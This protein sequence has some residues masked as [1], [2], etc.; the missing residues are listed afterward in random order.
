M[1]IDADTVMPERRVILHPSLAKRFGYGFYDDLGSVVGSRLEAM[2]LLRYD[3]SVSL[4]VFE[5]LCR[6]VQ[7]LLHMWDVKRGHTTRAG[8]IVFPF[9]AAGG[10]RS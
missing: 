7:W 5:E 10:A 8:L 1:T 6:R 3:S 4:P 2:L 9:Q